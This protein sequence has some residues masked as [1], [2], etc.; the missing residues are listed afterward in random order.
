MEV[1]ESLV[2]V[3]HGSTV[4]VALGQPMWELPRL[5][6]RQVVQTAAFI[7]AAGVRAIP[8][9]NETHI[10]TFESCHEETDIKTAMF[11][12][13]SLPAGL[14][15]GMADV[16][17]TFEDG[18]G[19]RIKNAAV[20]SWEGDQTERLGRHRVNIIGGE[21]E[22]AAGIPGVNWEDITTNWEDL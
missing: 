4:L 11:G 15:K 2:M 5:N 13:L 18:S 3:K 16:T 10:L 19:I 7:R 20:E 1:F 12:Q 6:G 9:G 21:I 14:P 22:I 8:R 17:V